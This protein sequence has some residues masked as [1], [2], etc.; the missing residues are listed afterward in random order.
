M[1]MMLLEQY[2]VLLDVVRQQYASVV[3][4]H[5]IQEKQAD[6][7]FK[8]YNCLETVNI[9]FASA[10]SC[11]IVSTIFFG[12]LC[13]KIITMFLSFV[14]LAI[15]AYYKS[16]DLKS[17]GYG[18]KVSANEFLVIRNRLLR[19]IADIHIHRKS[20]EEIEDDFSRVMETLD[21][22][23]A[24]AAQTTDDA[25]KMAMKGL[26]EREEYTYSNEEID[27]FLPS[28]LRGRID[29]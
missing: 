2:Q 23:Y 19:I 7:Y 9:I 22:L 28:Q 15:T 8:R 4:T 6:I 3:W 16:F 20:C 1:E 17:I 14:T 13:A 26:K 10:T 25:V 29:S 18:N 21:N 27:Q 11:G 24:R 12:E 5:K